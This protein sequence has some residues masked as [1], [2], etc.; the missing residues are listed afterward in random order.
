MKKKKK[1]SASDFRKLDE[2]IAK[3][4]SYALEDSKKD[5][6]TQKAY[7]KSNVSDEDFSLLWSCYENSDFSNG[8]SKEYQ[9]FVES[10]MRYLVQDLIGP[11]FKNSNRFEV[12]LPVVFY[13]LI[14]QNESNRSTVMRRENK[15]LLARKTGGTPPTWNLRDPYL[16]W[17][18][19]YR[20]DKDEEASF[21]NK[22]FD[23]S[24]QSTSTKIS[25]NSFIAKG[26]KNVI[27]VFPELSGCFYH[28]KFY[29]DI[30]RA[31][32][33]L[34]YVLKETDDKTRTVDTL[35]RMYCIVELQN[36]LQGCR[37]ICDDVIYATCNGYKRFKDYSSKSIIKDY[38]LTKLGDPYGNTIFSRKHYDF[39]VYYIG[40]GDSPNFDSVLNLNSK[41]ADIF[42][43]C[44]TYISE[45]FYFEMPDIIEFYLQEDKLSR[46]IN[47]EEVLLQYEKAVRNLLTF[48]PKLHRVKAKTAQVS[49]V[50][51]QIA[52]RKEMILLQ[53]SISAFAS[54][55][56]RAAHESKHSSTSIDEVIEDFIK[57][58]DRDPRE[59]GK[60]KLTSRQH[61][62]LGI[63][64]NGDYSAL[65]VTE[66]EL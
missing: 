39:L 50:C 9:N 18:K 24:K 21:S 57:M 34:Y 62:Q 8:I 42:E 61:V 20:P 65:N 51:A 52:K 4:A 27:S 22:I 44:Y 5:Y 49:Y 19:I 2:L 60:F 6:R 59:Y 1:L 3:C 47:A 23:I 35:I 40:D 30:S 48:L 36:V 14:V 15:V 31:G 26:V 25:E 7:G 17:K 54:E 55:A 29:S 43:E 45:N 66:E 37:A 63:D 11:C 38:S 28:A 32:Q 46:Y 56:E 12:M 58:L 41:G 33:F 16:E 64:E 13:S 53:D 10:E